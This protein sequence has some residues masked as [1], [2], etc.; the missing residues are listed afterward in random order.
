MARAWVALALAVASS[1]F[2][3]RVP[4]RGGLLVRRA[5]EVVEVS[6]S[7][8]LGITVQEV[9][10]AVVIQSCQPQA[11][12][13]GVQPGDEIVGVSAVFGD[14]VWD[15]RGQGLD[16]VEGLI[17]SREADAV[18]L[19]LERGGGDADGEAWEED[20][21]YYYDDDV[22]TATIKSIFDE[23]GDEDDYA[24]AEAAGDDA[25]ATMDAVQG[26]FSEGF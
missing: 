13:A 10:G 6:L 5:G 25:E 3:R 21:S 17:R 1:G 8:P 20:A 16:R 4:A 24:S 12:E 22:D 19:R 15:T 18:T 11:T 26:M 23:Y 7:R 2:Q 14:T 9:K